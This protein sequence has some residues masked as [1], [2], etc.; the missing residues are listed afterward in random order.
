MKFISSG[1]RI[2][3][4][5][6]NREF[7]ADKVLGLAKSYASHMKIESGD[8]VV[9]F[10]ENQLEYGAA[11]LSIWDKK[12]VAIMM[13][14]NSTQ[15]E[16]N[17]IVSDSLTKLIVTS[18]EKKMT[19]EE[20]I[21]SLGLTI[22]IF[23]YDV[24]EAEEAAQ[25]FEIESLSSEALIIYTSGT[26]GSPKGVVITFQNILTNIKSVKASKIINEGDDSFLM[27]LPHHHIFPIICMTLALYFNIRLDY[28]FK[29]DSESLKVGLAK[30]QPTIFIGVPRVYEMFHKG[31][32]AKIRA[33][34]L[35]VVMYK[36]AEKM[37]I[38]IRRKLFKKVHNTFGGKMDLLVSAGAK[39]PIEIIKD[40]RI[41]GFDILEAYGMTEC[42]PMISISS[43]GEFVP[44]GSVGRG[45]HLPE[46]TL[47]ISDIGEI[48]VK[49]PQVMKGYF[50]NEA[51]TKEVFTEEGYFK[52]GDRGE[53]RGEFL[54]L[55]GRIKDMIVLTNG[56]NVDP[57]TIEYDVIMEDKLGIIQEVAV[58]E[59]KNKLLA[60]VYPNMQVV[61]NNRISNFEAVVREVLNQYNATAKSYLK[62]LDFKIVQEEFPKTRIGKIKRFM[63]KDIANGTAKLTKKSEMKEPTTES[64]VMLK[65]FLSELKQCEISADSHIEFDLGLDSLEFLELQSYIK[66]SFGIHMVAPELADKLLVHQ[67]A[68]FIEKNKEFSVEQVMNFE[69]VLN[70]PYDLT[71]PKGLFV[72]IAQIRSRH[73]FKKQSNL[74]IKGLENIPERNVIFAGNH[75]SFVDAFI[76]WAAMPYKKMKS[77]YFIAKHTNFDRAWKRFLGRNVNTMIMDANENAMNSVQAAAYILKKNKN[78]IIFPEGTRTPDGEIYPF[79]R[80]FAEL[81]ATLK[82]PVVPFVIYGAFEAFPKTSKKLK[83]VKYGNIVIEFLPLVESADSKEILRVTQKNIEAKFKEYRLTYQKS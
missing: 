48:L 33:K 68:Q 18:K 82:I 38:T 80:T 8:N 79:R 17:H 58:L 9:L 32:M 22:P 24:F 16:F 1:T 28:V 50:N 60:L 20:Y 41:L 56:K 45:A 54:F 4:R 35:S 5:D 70:T 27:I 64:Y 72:W 66:R 69:E 77:S 81:S 42:A 2:V 46:C 13:D 15:E 53:L 26:T 30:F 61:L 74:I 73:G 43:R 36:M 40:F 25:D 34:K 83:E 52:T 57:N 47:K 29:L 12:A 51:A 6:M 23:V 71:L 76:F 3:M 65:R 37:P 59:F 49:G 39:L 19:A 7:S 21:T 55:D 67:L 75:Q 44:L 78:L 14:A 63:L 62:V 11:L 10:S 31:I